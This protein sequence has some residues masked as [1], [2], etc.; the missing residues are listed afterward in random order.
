LCLKP[1]FALRRAAIDSTFGRAKQEPVEAPATD[2][3]Q[4]SSNNICRK[5]SSEL[6]PPVALALNAA[7]FRSHNHVEN[8]ETTLKTC[9]Q[10]FVAV[11]CILEASDVHAERIISMVDLW[12]LVPLGIVFSRRAN[13]PDELHG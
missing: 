6:R 10:I 12:P 8:T 2:M 3:R 4:T 13:E 9:L 5:I 11:D 1:D 7:Q